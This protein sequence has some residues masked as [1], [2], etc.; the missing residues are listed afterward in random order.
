[1]SRN[2]RREQ[3]GSDTETSIIFD[4]LASYATEQGELVIH[5]ERHPLAWV[6]ADEEDTMEVE[7]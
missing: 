7:R 1:M 5:D 2:D 6:S 3:K 4:S